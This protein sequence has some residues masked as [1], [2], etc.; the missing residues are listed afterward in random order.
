M[1]FGVLEGVEGFDEVKHGVFGGEYFGFLEFEG[2][3][4][5]FGVDNDNRGQ[6]IRFLLHQHPLSLQ[7]FDHDRLVFNFALATAIIATVAHI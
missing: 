3:V 1:D 5:G 4:R 7:I 6:C 2:L